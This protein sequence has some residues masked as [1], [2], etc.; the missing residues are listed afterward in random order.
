MPYETRT[1]RTSI[2]DWT[3][4]ADPWSIRC[5]SEYL[6][7]WPKADMAITDDSPTH[8]L[9]SLKC[10]IVEVFEVLKHKQLSPH[11]QRQ[12]AVLEEHVG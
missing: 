8:A 10:E 4:T 7:S 5:M 12:L 6:A 11:L 1:H 2:R 9:Q 3:L